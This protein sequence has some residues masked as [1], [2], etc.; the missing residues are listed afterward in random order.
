MG[1]APRNDALFERLPSPTEVESARMLHEAL[2][3]FGE[4]KAPAVISV[5]HG[6]EEETFELL[7]AVAAT[8]VDVLRHFARGKAVTLVPIGAEMTTQQ[9]ADMLN[10][11]R[12]YL[13]KLIDQG[14]LHAT[15]VGR[16]RRIPAT[17]VF[18]FKH[19]RD[20]ARNAALDELMAT[21]SD[22]I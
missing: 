2:A 16:H 17:E 14:E 5:K 3:R 8:L 20:A 12:P 11:S 21:D 6:G 7:P 19:R 13:I 1:L 10:V 18:A 15:K 22:A 9:A 4:R